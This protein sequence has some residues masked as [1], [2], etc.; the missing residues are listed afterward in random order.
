MEDL[1]VARQLRWEAAFRYA[2]EHDLT[3]KAVLAFT[4]NYAKTI[5]EEND[6]TKWPSIEEAFIAWTHAQASRKKGKGYDNESNAGN[7]DSGSE[8][9]D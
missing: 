3:L 4:R 6:E 5:K 7:D 9:D 2:D 8:S 1:A